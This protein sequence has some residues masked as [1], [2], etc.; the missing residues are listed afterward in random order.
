M[1]SKEVYIVYNKKISIESQSIGEQ[2][3]IEDCE[4]MHVFNNIICKPC[5]INNV[6]VCKNYDYIVYWSRI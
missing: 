5:D 1:C 3:K 4:S 6:V 2:K